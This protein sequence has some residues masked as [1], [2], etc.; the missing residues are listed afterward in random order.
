MSTQLDLQRLSFAANLASNG[1]RTA[2]A[3]SNGVLTYRELAGRVEELGRRLGSER[4]LV[5]LTA[6][7]DVDSL[8]G[9][10]RPWRP[11]IR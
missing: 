6:G 9:T 11:V 4:R 10:W 1:D 5:A 8:V 7:N 2:V 3:T